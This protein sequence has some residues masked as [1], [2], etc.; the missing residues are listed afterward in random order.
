M[1][2][3]YKYVCNIYSPNTLVCELGTNVSLEILNLKFFERTG[4]IVLKTKP[5]NVKKKKMT[6]IKT[7]DVH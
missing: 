2:E 4:L 6:L 5:I 7:Y 3:D 1:I